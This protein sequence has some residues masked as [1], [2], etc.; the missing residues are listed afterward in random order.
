MTLYN[1]ASI[2]TDACFYE[3][4]D[5]ARTCMHFL[6]SSMET[7]LEARLLDDLSPDLVAA[8]STSVQEKQ[9]SRMPIS[10]SGFLVN[11]LL[12]KHAG[13]LSELD[14]GRPTGGARKFKP[15]T[16]TSA[17]SPLL[18]PSTSPVLRPKAFASPL[19]SPM[20]QPLREDAPFE[21]DDFSL[22]SSTLMGRSSV[23]ST[24][25]SATPARSTPMRAAASGFTPGTSP[26]SSSFMTLGSPPPARLQPW[27]KAESSK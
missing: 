5:L 2:L 19:L 14:Y 9:G 3:A 1:V 25:G 7:V 11:E 4:P 24:S 18:S 22:D 15:V 13:W 12:D 20:L 17:R 8:L 16:L 10:R 27:V 21:M 6:A 26:S 23:A